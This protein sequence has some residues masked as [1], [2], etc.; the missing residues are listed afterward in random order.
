MEEQSNVNPQIPQVPQAEESK[1]G[2]II[3]I[4]LL[5]I[6]FTVAGGLIYKFIE[7]N[8]LTEEK[9]QKE[10]ELEAT[11]DK[12]DSISN[13]LDTKILE[14]SQLGG[15][16]NSLL[17]VK[18]QL[19]A[20]KK[21][22]RKRTNNE[23]TGLKDK[24]SGYKELLL[25]QDKEIIWL[26]TI[27][28]ELMVENT[29]LKTDKV[30]LSDSLI[31]LNKSNLDLEQQVAFAGRLKVEDMRISAVNSKG[32]ERIGEF[33]NRH[34]N[35]LKIQFNIPEN[36]VS[37]IEGKDIM[38]RITTPDGNVLFDVTSGSGTFIYDNREMFF[39][40]KQKI[41]YDR[42]KQNIS[43]LY[44]KGSEYPLGKHSVEVY[45]DDYLMGKGSFIVK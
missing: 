17:Q 12:L 34:I 15:E 39:T 20:D 22:I 11:Y 36:K 25:Q 5:F 19:E 10:T 6:L 42:T 26:K 29:E 23:I 14:I 45:T 41:L 2:N 28:E 44:N 13:A 32:K 30:Q 24:V 18:E 1:K 33:K 40:A 8:T 9:Q 4:V 7:I 31:N 37:P 38:I 43:F 16:I 21:L 35:Q 27:N 3:I